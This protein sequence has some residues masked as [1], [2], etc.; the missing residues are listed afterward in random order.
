MIALRQNKNQK[1]T[2][3]LDKVNITKKAKEQVNKMKVKFKIKP[4][5]SIPVSKERTDCQDWLLKSSRA[6][7]K[8]TNLFMTAV[9]IY[10]SNNKIQT[11]KHI[12]SFLSFLHFL[13]LYLPS[14]LLFCS[15]LY[16]G[17]LP[18]FHYRLPFILSPFFSCSSFSHFLP[19]FLTTCPQF[20]LLLRRSNNRTPRSAASDSL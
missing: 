4:L 16:M 1:T 2:S 15:L 11:H 9:T 19:S 6:S 12:K 20:F 18:S 17:F 7:R 13:I 14:F 8:I 3:I 5:H 10:C